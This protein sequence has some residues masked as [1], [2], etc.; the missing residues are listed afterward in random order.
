ME[1]LRHSLLKVA[2][3]PVLLHD[4]SQFLSPLSLQSQLPS[5]MAE[6]KL[7]NARF[8][9]LHCSHALLL[10]LLLDLLVDEVLLTQIDLLLYAI[11][12][13][14]PS[15]RLLVHL[16]VENLLLLGKLTFFILSLCPLQ[17]LPR[18]NL[19]LQLLSQNNFAS[20]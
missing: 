10:T 12:Q 17:L 20:S 13:S 16:L 7:I 6:Y 1:R 8:L 19:S 4:A 2:H 11:T 9:S 3:D 15:L 5:L 18:P 14:M